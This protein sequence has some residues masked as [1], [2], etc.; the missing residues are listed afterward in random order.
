MMLKEDVELSLRLKETGR[1]V[2]LRDGIL[3][4]G[5]RWQASHFAANLVTVFRLFP[6]YLLAR[7]FKGPDS[8]N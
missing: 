8:L 2:F 4:S 7:R 5:R 1:V 3:A 6:R